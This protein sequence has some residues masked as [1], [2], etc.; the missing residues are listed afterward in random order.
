[1]NRRASYDYQLFERFEAGVHL[2]GAE[3]KAIRQGNAD[4]AGG[5]VR[6][7]GSEAFL[8]NIKIYPYQYARPDDYDERR[9]RKLLLHKKEIVA[10][11]SKTE[12]ANLT[13]VP[14]SLYT[15]G[16]LIK[17]ELALGKGK[18]KH[19]KKRTIKERDLDRDLEY[20]MDKY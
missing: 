5:F 13:I 4:L 12:G 1:M 6:I 18:T 14:V 15:K 2:N 17:L 16:H 10:L 20:E 3:V 19:D 9:S 7:R 8:T 11:K